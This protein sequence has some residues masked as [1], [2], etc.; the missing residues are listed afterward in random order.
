MDAREVGQRIAASRRRRG[1][2]QAVLAGLVG[3]SESWLSQVERGKRTID[4][5][6]VLLRLS[7]ILGLDVADLI[8][9]SSEERVAKYQAASAVADVMTSYT[10]LPAAIKPDRADH[11]PRLSWLGHELRQV[12]RLYQ[13]AKYD[14]AGKRLPRLINA[15][16]YAS[17]S[18]PKRD[19]RRANTLRALIYQSAATTLSRVGEPELAL[20]AGDRSVTAAETAER[21]L[22]VAVSAYRLGYALTA[23]KRHAQAKSVALET[24]DALRST[25]R[26]PSPLVTSVIGGLYLV[27]VTAAAAA[28]DRAEV[29]LWL[30]A[31]RATADELGR[32]RNDFWTAFGPTNVRIHEISAAVR[33]GDPRQAIDKAEVLDPSDLGPGLVGR[34]AQ[35]LLDLARAYGQQRKDAAAV[36]T[37]LDA[38]RLS[39]ELVR[40]DPRTQDLLT[41]LI[42]REHHASTP[43]LR[44]LARRA[45][46]I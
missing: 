28:F 9:Q 16:E 18:V 39:P 24:A 17:H 43:Q 37:M 27:A 8:A 2:S 34:R 26:R 33:F 21:P 20:T 11:D 30:Q 35:V 46:V 1:L 40:Y 23:M 6:S 44:S 45:G 3:R 29:D 19:R 22:L 10:S 41:E 13:A 32:D 25:A 4:A 38:E 7:E 12:N 14:D 36:N 15:A 42:K 31:A 5:H